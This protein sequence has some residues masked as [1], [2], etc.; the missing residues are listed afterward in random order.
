MGK[1]DHERLQGTWAFVSEE[2]GG[3]QVEP[4]EEAKGATL[5]F[6]GDRA[7]F[8]QKGGGHEASFKLDPTR[9]P[10]EIDLTVEEGGKSAVHKGLYALEG[11]TLKMCLA[12]PPQPRPTAFASVAGERWPAVFVFKRK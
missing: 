4:P 11:D 5:T 6:Q 3:K 1:S 8:K 10:K 12:H 7:V 2:R 9:T